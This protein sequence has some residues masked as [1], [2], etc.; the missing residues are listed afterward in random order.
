MPGAPSFEYFNV[1]IAN[2]DKAVEATT[3]YLAKG[4]V[5]AVNVGASASTKGPATSPLSCTICNGSDSET[6]RVR[7]LSSPRPRRRQRLRAGRV[8]Q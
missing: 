7:L 6:L 1:G 2:P 8:G 4:K 3:K 5:D